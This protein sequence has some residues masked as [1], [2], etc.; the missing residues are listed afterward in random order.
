MAEP[1]IAAKAPIVREMEPG[2]YWWCSCGKSQTQPFCD[3]THKGTEFRPIK[4]ELTEK[5]T[6]AW[7]ACKHS[8]NAPYCD[9]THAGLT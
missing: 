8:K 2:T 4:V 1:N 3:G 9:G 7:C 5:R 6:L